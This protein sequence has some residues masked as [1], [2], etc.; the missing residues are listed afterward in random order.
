MYVK[1]IVFLCGLCSYVDSVFYFYFLY[2]QPALLAEI[3]DLVVNE[4]MVI[5]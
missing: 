3:V 1:C 4:F 5:F 2:Y